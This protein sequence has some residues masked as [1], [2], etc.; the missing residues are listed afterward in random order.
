MLALSRSSSTHEL[1]VLRATEGCTGVG[2]SE[3]TGELLNKMDVH[4]RVAAPGGSS[5][6]IRR[7]GSA[8]FDTKLKMAREVKRRVS[9]IVGV[10]RVAAAEMLVTSAAGSSADLTQRRKRIA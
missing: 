6:M 4:V 2:E 8:E 5:K 10:E 1:A 7:S 9:E 3:Y